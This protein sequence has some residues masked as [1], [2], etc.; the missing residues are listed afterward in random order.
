MLIDKFGEKILSRFTTEQILDA[1]EIARIISERIV[2]KCGWCR[3]I[4]EFPR[5]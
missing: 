5:M 2:C 3:T 4:G 1:R